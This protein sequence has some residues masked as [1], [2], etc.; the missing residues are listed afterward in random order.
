MEY[1]GIILLVFSLIWF[2]AVSNK[3][4][5]HSKRDRFYATFCLVA[6]LCII[7]MVDTMF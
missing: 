7:V 1:I 2:I 5:A 3:T 4:D 6:S